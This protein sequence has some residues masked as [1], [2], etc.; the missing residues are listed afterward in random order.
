MARVQNETG[1]IVHEQFGNPEVN[2]GDLRKVKE[3]FHPRKETGKESEDLHALR[4][5]V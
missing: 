3:K 1:L 2:A 4:L 5:D